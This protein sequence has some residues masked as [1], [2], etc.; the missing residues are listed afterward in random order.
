MSRASA[1]SRR[2]SRL[3]L[4]LLERAAITPGRLLDVGCGP[5]WAL[6]E[7]Q[8]AGFEVHGVDASPGAV[9][10]AL[11]WGLSAQ[12]LDIEREEL[13]AG[14]SLISAFEVLEHLHDPLAVLQ[15]MARA[16]EPGG[17]LLVSL[18]NEFHLPRR[19]AILAGRPG[20]G[21]H[22]K[23]GGHADPHLRL[24]T[25]G[26][27]ERLFE[28]GSLRVVGRAWDGLLPPRYRALQGLSGW[29]ASAS[30]SLFALSG[31]YLLAPREAGSGEQ[32]GA[33]K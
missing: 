11:E 2:R 21:G 26:S 20:A 4:R 23:F 1:R 18:P 13:P 10:R 9:S 12:V 24:F 33:V 3:A 14:F 30:P 27:S 7:F 15:K 25:P 32:E 8:A 17:R 6:E 28:E 29:L 19:I 5:G 16:L 31:V 22:R